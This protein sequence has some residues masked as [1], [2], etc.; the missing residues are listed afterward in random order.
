MEVVDEVRLH[1]ADKIGSLE[2]EKLETSLREAVRKLELD[3]LP[4]SWVDPQ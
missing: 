2:L 3:Y 1:Y 4:E